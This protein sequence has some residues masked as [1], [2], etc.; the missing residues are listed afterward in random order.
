MV[1]QRRYFSSTSIFFIR[2]PPLFAKTGFSVTFLTFNLRLLHSQNTRCVSEQKLVGPRISLSLYSDPELSIPCN[3]SPQRSMP[4]SCSLFLCPQKPQ[5]HSSALSSQCI[6]QQTFPFPVQF[7]ILQH[8]ITN[9]HSSTR[10]RSHST[11]IHRSPQ[12]EK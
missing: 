4:I 9:T 3:T 6:L 11:K 5:I 8:I 1:C 10:L 7:L 2:L 12:G